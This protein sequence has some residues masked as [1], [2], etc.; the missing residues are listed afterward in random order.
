MDAA[1]KKCTGQPQCVIDTLT[2][3][4]REFTG[5]D[6]GKDDQTIVVVRHNHPDDAR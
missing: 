6:I 1:L 2:N 4:V 3:A 5:S